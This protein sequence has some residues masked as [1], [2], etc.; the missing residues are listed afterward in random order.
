MQLRVAL[1]GRPNVGKSTLFNN[2]IG[3]HLAITAEEAGTTRD[4]IEREVMINRVKFILTDAGGVETA[5]GGDLDD[6]IQ[7]QVQFAIANSD[8]LVFM[9]DAKSEITAEDSHAA[10]MLRRT[11]KPVIFVANKFENDDVTN[12][13]NFAS[14]GFDVPLGIS[15][16]HKNGLDELKS[17]LTKKLRKIR[18]EKKLKPEK[19]EMK[20]AAKVAVVGRPNVGKSSLVNKILGEKRFVVSEI[21]C[22]TRDV[23]DAV[24]EVNGQKFQLLDTAGIRRA[25]KIGKGIDRFAT[26]RTLNAI[27]DADVALL[28]LDGS[29]KVVAQDLHVAEKVLAAGCGIIIVVNKIDLWDEF[30]TAQKTWLNDLSARFQFARWVSVVMLSAETGRHIPNL[31][32]QILAVQAERAKQIPTPEL[33]R[34]FKKIVSQHSPAQTD[35]AKAPPKIYYVTQLKNQRQPTFALVVNRPLAFHFSYRRFIENRLREEYGFAGVP[36]KIEFRERKRDAR[37]NAERA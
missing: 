19:T 28:L 3:K 25:G 37:K 36:L 8:L 24:V 17:I 15:A 23:G 1:I 31:F 21:P 12:L 9:V 13:M 20:I 22:T 11:S 29:E 7:R 26:G 16:I 10:E 18:S 6:D 33:N 32:E 27:S 30:E 14:F 5:S 2:L 35:N 4:R 34:F